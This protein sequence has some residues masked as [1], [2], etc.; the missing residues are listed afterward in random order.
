MT[1]TRIVV[2]TGVF[3]LLAALISA[4]SLIF[5]DYLARKRSSIDDFRMAAVNFAGQAQDRQNNAGM[6]ASTIF[7]GASGEATMEELIER[8]I[9]YDDSYRIQNASVFAHKLALS[10][11]L[12][13]S[14][15]GKVLINYIDNEIQADLTE[16]DIIVTEAYGQVIKSESFSEGVKILDE[17][18]KTSKRKVEA[19]LAEV[20][21]QIDILYRSPTYP[22]PFLNSSP[23]SVDAKSLDRTLGRACK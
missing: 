6:L 1:N 4:A 17:D 2:S 10:P 3:G 13:K 12:S 22:I 19:C 8:K 7:R 18:Y 9:K 23:Y 20:I 15:H 5:S 11:I 21:W 14:E 16:L